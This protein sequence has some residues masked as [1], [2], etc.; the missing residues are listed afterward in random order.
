MTCPAPDVV[1]W[2]SGVLDTEVT[3]LRGLRHGDSPWLLRAGDREVVLR[4]ARADQA[5]ETATEVAA[6]TYAASVA[7]ASLPVAE[8]LGYDLAERTGYGLVLTACVSGTSVIPPE[9]DPVRLRALGAAAARI[10]SV[11]L[12]PTPVLPVRRRPIEADDFASMRRDQGASDLLRAAEAAVAEARPDDDR[13]GLVHGDLWHGNTLWDNDKLTAVLDWD[14]AGVGPAGI[15]LGSLR[16]DAAWCHDVEAAE[17]ILRGWEAEA[18]RP[19]SNVFY[20]DA[21]AALASPPDMGWF[22]ASMAAQGRH[23]LTRE[24]MLERRDAF[25]NAALGRLAAVG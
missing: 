14:C 11:K 6:M 2:A 20:W 1:A 22:P 13:L 23:D 5:A 16:C 24:V 21:V 10:S 15:D 8:L 19:A 18:G 4:V 7:G 17:G 9:P 3:V 25:L 12:T